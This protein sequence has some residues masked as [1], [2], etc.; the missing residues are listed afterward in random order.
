[1][2]SFFGSSARSTS[3]LDSLRYASPILSTTD[4]LPGKAGLVTEWHQQCTAGIGSAYTAPLFASLSYDKAG[5]LLGSK[6]NIA[7]AVSG[8]DMLTEQGITYDCSGNLLTLRRYG[9]GSPATPVD[10]LAFTYNGPKRNGWSYDAHG[11]T[12]ADPVDSTSIAWNVLDLPRSVAS[13]T[14]SAQRQYLSDGTL[15]SVHDGSQLR[16]YLGDMVFKVASGALALE[17]AGWEGGRLLPGTGADKALYYVNDHLGSVRV[18]KDGSGAIRQYYS[19]YPYGSVAMSWS[20]NASTDTP[21]KRYRFGGKEIAGA[22][23]NAISS[24]SAPYLDFGARL[25]S[26]RTATWLSQ[27]PIAES[28]YPFTPYLYCAGSPVNVV[29]PEGLHPIYALDGSF[30]GTDDEGLQGAPLFMDP[31]FFRQGMPFSEAKQYDVGFQGLNDENAVSLFMSSYCSLPLRPDWDGF[32]TLE[33]ANEWYRT[34]NGQPLY[35]SLEKIDL[36]GLQ[37]LGEQKVGQTKAISL[38][39]VSSVNDALVYGKITLR[40]YPHHM[41][42][43]FADTYNFDMKPWRNPINWGRN[44]ET[45]IGHKVAG[46]GKEYEINIYGSKRLMPVLPWIK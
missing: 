27:D 40:R 24:G 34:G 21:E 6:M 11:N 25:Y 35:V 37:S 46:E 7:G 32:L 17:G 10:S 4:P 29:D 20:A 2:S 9:T 39:L 26:P 43:A 41:V 23:T 30:L 15:Y 18:V 38:F 31:N 8:L 44:V 16:I 22:V 3:Y 28:Y 13:G 14:A 19:Y 5:R 33:E 42:R 36:S 45:I 1:M 12:T